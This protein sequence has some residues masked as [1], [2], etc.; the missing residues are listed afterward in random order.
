[1]KNQLLLERVLK[2]RSAAVP[3]S[4]SR[5]TTRIS[6]PST[7]SQVL[8]LVFDTAALHF[9]ST[10]LVSFCFAAC[11]ASCAAGAA[12]TAETNNLVLAGAATSMAMLDDQHKLGP[13]DRITYRVIED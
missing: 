12:G 3:S 6:G 11:V 13:G 8:R 10:L 2:I 9:R 7:S 4:T 5:S 1:M